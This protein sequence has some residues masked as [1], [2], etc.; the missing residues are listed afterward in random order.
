MWLSAW[1]FPSFTQG[2]TLDEVVSSLREAIALQIEGE[3]LADFGLTRF[4]QLPTSWTPH[5]AVAAP[6]DASACANTL[7]Q[8]GELLNGQ[9][10]LLEDVREGGP[11]DGAMRGDD[12]L[13]C[14]VAHAFV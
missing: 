13:E 3:D 8:T 5:P 1:T 6:N 14:L 10:R 4:R 7:K 2:A 11:L 9:P 12:Q